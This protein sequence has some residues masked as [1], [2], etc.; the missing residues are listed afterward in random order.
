VTDTLDHNTEVRTALIEQMRGI[1]ETRCVRDQDPESAVAPQFEWREVANGTGG[2]K[3][4]FE[5]YASVVERGYHVWA[6]AIGDF[7]EVIDRRAFDQSLRQSPDVSFKLNHAGLP[8]ARSAA[9][10]LRLSADNTGLFS[11]ADLN[12]ERAD[13]KLLRQAIEAGHLNE[14]SFGFRVDRQEW[15]PDGQ[16]RR[17]L[18]AN[19]HRGDVSIVEHGANPATAN[20]F[21]LRNQLTDRGITADSLQDAFRALTIFNETR[22][23]DPEVEALLVTVLTLTGI[24]DSAVDLSQILLSDTLGVTNPDEAQDEA[25]EGA[26]NDVDATRGD[27]DTLETRGTTAAILRLRMLAAQG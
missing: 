27:T 11:D 12:P 16:E 13:V 8:M 18:S 9:G 25:L 4:H 5:G 20:L 7:T 2:T 24:A 21:T 26:D 23:L 3:L 22:S 14:M 15:T 10:D 6:P 1:T 17:V 19:L